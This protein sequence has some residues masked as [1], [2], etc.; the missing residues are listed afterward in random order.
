MQKNKFINYQEFL[1]SIKDLDTYYNRALY[2]HAYMCSNGFTSE[3]FEKTNNC[4]EIVPT[5]LRHQFYTWVHPSSYGDFAAYENIVDCV[6]DRKDI[7]RY[8]E[9]NVNLIDVNDVAQ[10]FKDV[11]S[12]GYVAENLS[13]DYYSSFIEAFKKLHPEIA[14]GSVILEV[15]Q[16]TNESNTEEDKENK[17]LKKLYFI[18]SFVIAF[19]C[20]VVFKLGLIKKVKDVRRNTNNDPK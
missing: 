10:Y 8:A 12:A 11:L 17:G 14:N 1:F 6:N 19:V 5:K 18:V 9:T 7:D 20:V 16:N 13:E 15:N 4:F 3:L 2:T